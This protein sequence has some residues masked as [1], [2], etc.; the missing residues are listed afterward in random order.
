MREK[1]R[2]MRAYYINMRHITSL[3][4]FIAA[5]LVSMSFASVSNAVVIPGNTTVGNPVA[6]N[7]VVPPMG[8]MAVN[9]AVNPGTVAKALP[10][11][12]RPF[13]LGVKS[14]GLG[15]RP[16]GFGVRPFGFGFRPFGFGFNPF[17]DA[18]FDAFGEFA[19]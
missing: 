5:L 4:A 12:A 11:D 6:V 18:D 10:S 9:T 8:V 1:E 7:A 14:F 15:V 17:F 2:A 16:F 3:M 19:D 13:G